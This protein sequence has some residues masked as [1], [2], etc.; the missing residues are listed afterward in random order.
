MKS[1]KTLQAMATKIAPF[2]CKINGMGVVQ[3]ERC[4]AF[5]RYFESLEIPG[6]R[7]LQFVLFRRIVSCPSL[8]LLTRAIA[9]FCVS[10]Q[11]PDAM[12]HQIAVGV[13]LPTVRQIGRDQPPDPV[14]PIGQPA[15]GMHRHRA[16]D[17]VFI[18][19]IQDP[20]RQIHHPHQPGKASTSVRMA[21]ISAMSPCSRHSATMRNSLAGGFIRLSGS[22]R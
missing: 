14:Q 7:F 1:Y 11:T 12:P 8:C 4:K 9:P 3:G 22:W 2:Q 19:R 6:L 15:F 5:R 13:N 16:A 18:P 17:L 20:D 21:A 10:R